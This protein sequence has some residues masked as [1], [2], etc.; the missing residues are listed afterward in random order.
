MIKTRM[1]KNQKKTDNINDDGDDDNTVTC[2]ST[3]GVDMNMIK[4]RITKT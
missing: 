4:K 3:N 1:Q 2:I